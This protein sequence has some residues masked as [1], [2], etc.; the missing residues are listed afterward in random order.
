MT[1]KKT[2]KYIHKH[3]FTL[4][5]ILITIVII[6]IL[7]G[8]TATIVNTKQRLIDA[9]RAVQINN[10]EKLAQGI[11]TFC[12]VEG[13]CPSKDEVNNPGPGNVLYELYL[14]DW[15]TKDEIGKDAAGNPVYAVYQYNNDASGDD[16]KDATYFEIYG[17]LAPGTAPGTIDTA[18]KN[19]MRYVKYNSQVGLSKVCGYSYIATKKY[20]ATSWDTCDDESDIT[21][22]VN[23]CET[24]TPP[25][26]NCSNWITC[27]D[28]KTLCTNPPSSSP[29]ECFTWQNCDDGV[30]KL[31]LT[32]AP[33]APEWCDNWKE[34][35]GVNKYACVQPMVPNTVIC[36]H[37]APCDDAL[38]VKCTSSSSNPNPPAPAWCTP[39]DLWVLC[40]KDTYACIHLLTPPNSKCTAIDVCDNNLGDRCIRSA[41]L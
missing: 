6:G 16:K 21:N 34:C 19:E 40:H 38:G 15:P 2:I 7:S 11:S 41:P 26:T 3:G 24:T 17:P 33:A 22:T 20:C 1:L 36:S 39:A 25:P 4:I 32:S 12:N 23:S 27:H 5:E 37:S 9:K 28:T 13:Y 8:I 35:I 18:S 29:T 14:K 30:N 10:V 31:C